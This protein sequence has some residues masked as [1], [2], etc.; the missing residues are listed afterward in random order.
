VGHAAGQVDKDHALG[1]AFFALV[2]LLLGLSGLDAKK[3]GQRQAN[4]ANKT[5]VQKISA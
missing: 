2:K 3:I 1:R 5:N 4:A